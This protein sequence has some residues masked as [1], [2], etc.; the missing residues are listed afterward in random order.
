[1][2]SRIRDGAAYFEGNEQGDLKAEVRELAS[3]SLKFLF[4]HIC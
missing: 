4:P 3:I 1:M 2:V